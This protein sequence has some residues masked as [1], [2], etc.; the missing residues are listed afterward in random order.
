MSGDIPSG[1]GSE[2]NEQIDSDVFA[3]SVGGSP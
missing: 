2:T 3:G 1:M